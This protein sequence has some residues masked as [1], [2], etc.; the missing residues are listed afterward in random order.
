MEPSAQ[1]TG[2]RAEYRDLL[3][4]A[5]DLDKPS[6]P[7]DELAFH[8]AAIGTAEPVLEVM[9]GSGRFLLPLLAT[10]VDVD[11]VD[12]S[13]SMLDACREHARDR[14]L[15]VSGRLYEQRAEDLRL[16][17]RYRAAFCAAGSWGLLAGDDEV[18]RA[19]AAVRAHL[20]QGGAFHFEVET[21]PGPPGAPDGVLWW[22]RPDGAVITAR[23]GNRIDPVTGLESGVGIYELFVDGVLVHTELNNWVR[24]FWT[25]EAISA[26]V[27]AAGFSEVTVRSGHSDAP[28]GPDDLVLTVHATR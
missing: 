11:G 7:A 14:G 26:A 2:Y 24:R 19:L 18:A 6:A 1:P 23:G 21:G 3:T 5:Y 17:R 20:L 16:R 13:P 10:G 28:P 12:A 25:P 22:T 4:Q 9:C 27:G 8:L 15:D